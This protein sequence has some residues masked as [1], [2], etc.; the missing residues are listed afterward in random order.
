MYL[1]TK[2]CPDTFILG[3]SNSGRREECVNLEDELRGVCFFNLWKIQILYFGKFKKK[4][5]EFFF[6]RKSP[7]G[8][9]SLTLEESGGSTNHYK[10]PHN[11]KNNT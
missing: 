5:Q 3:T 1:D 9:R 10:G 11:K 2:L 8:P 6:E 7:E 4:I